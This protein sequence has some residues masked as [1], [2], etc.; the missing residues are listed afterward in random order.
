MRTTSRIT[1]DSPSASHALLVSSSGAS[2]QAASSATNVLSSVKTGS[3]S[4]QAP[5]ILILY[6]ASGGRML[7]LRRTLLAWLQFEPSTDNTRSRLLTV[8]SPEL[9]RSHSP[10]AKV[11]RR[12]PFSSIPLL[13][14]Q[15]ALHEAHNRPHLDLHRPAA[16]RLLAHHPH[17]DLHRPAASRLLA[18][19]LRVACLHLL[20]VRQAL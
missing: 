5:G 10:A 6:T 19:L 2:G 12:S 18:H 14:Q 11:G 1:S 3:P 9:S 13:R 15:R 17:P 20:H 7:P 8:E 4:R 16:P